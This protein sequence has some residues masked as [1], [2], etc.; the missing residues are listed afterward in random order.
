MPAA[1]PLL[2]VTSAR[3]WRG[4][5]V[6]AARRPSAVYDAV[7]LGPRGAAGGL[8]RDALGEGGDVE[9][10]VGGIGFGGQVLLVD[11]LL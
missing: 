5:P 6:S 3:S 7:Q 4:L 8:D 2:A 1:T 11:G 9:G 10:E